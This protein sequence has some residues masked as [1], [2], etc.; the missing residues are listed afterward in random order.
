MSKSCV[1]LLIIILSEHYINN[2]VFLTK[3]QD[4]LLCAG[5]SCKNIGRWCSNLIITGVASDM[6][7]EQIVFILLFLFLKIVYFLEVLI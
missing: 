5:L 3:K 1:T 6:K 2:G 4:F 7:T